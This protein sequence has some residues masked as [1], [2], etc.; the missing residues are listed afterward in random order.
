M[1]PE[2]CL[3]ILKPP[4]RGPLDRDKAFN[5]KPKSDIHQKPQPE[6]G[7]EKDNKWTYAEKMAT[8]NQN[9]SYSEVTN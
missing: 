2:S 3:E 4:D 8:S 6:I 9:F 1:P 7:E 5:Q